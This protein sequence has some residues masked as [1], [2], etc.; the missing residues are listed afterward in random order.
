VARD[1]KK[2]VPKNDESSEIGIRDKEILSED[3]KKKASTQK[4]EKE[5]QKPPANDE[6]PEMNSG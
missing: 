3:D 1:E 5:T 2:E 4:I 6:D